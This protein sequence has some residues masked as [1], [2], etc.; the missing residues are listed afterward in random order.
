MSRRGKTDITHTSLSILNV[1]FILRFE[2]LHYHSITVQTD[3]S[4]SNRVS[5]TDHT[6]TLLTEEDY[7]CKLKLY[8][9]KQ[10]YV[11]SCVKS[12]EDVRYL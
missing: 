3:D 1:L 10:H 8:T 6:T 2:N 7:N 9:G 5:I 11:K 4:Q 12:R